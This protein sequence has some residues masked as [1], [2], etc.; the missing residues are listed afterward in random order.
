MTEAKY[1]PGCR[2]ILDSLAS[3]GFEVSLPKPDMDDYVKKL[4][5]A[6][7][8]IRT[9]MKCKQSTKDEDADA[10][11]AAILAFHK[12]YEGK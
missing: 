1:S 3:Y 2:F 8:V 12:A 10:H 9:A 4:T 7:A 5:A 6:H 11:K